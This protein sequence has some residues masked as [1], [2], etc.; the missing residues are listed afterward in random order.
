MIQ[1][2]SH[3]P[4]VPHRKEDVSPLAV[5]GEE[6]EIALNQ[7][8]LSPHRKDLAREGD[9]DGEGGGQRMANLAT[10][11]LMIA[12]CLLFL[13]FCYIKI[14]LGVPGTGGDVPSLPPEATNN[15]L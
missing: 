12:L 8:A 3:L 14:N 1:Q 13:Y 9:A 11:V 4:Q 15:R 2:D 10:N 7:L 5:V 6:E